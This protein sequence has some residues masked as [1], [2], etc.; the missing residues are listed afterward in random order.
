MEDESSVM[1]ESISAEERHTAEAGQLRHGRTSGW[2]AQ[3]EACKA[4]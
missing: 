1:P 4:R 2:G 3:T